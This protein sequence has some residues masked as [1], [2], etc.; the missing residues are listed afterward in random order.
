MTSSADI[1][2]DL[3]GALTPEVRISLLREEL[4]PKLLAHFQDPTAIKLVTPLP[5]KTQDLQIA[6]TSALDTILNE[7]DDYHKVLFLQSALKQEDGVPEFS[8]G[9]IGLLIESELIRI[10]ALG[11][12]RADTRDLVA[13][14]KK[15]L[16]PQEP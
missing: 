5:P 6:I 12:I 14:F 4:E 15:S 8:E 7:L 11:N 1:K 2:V 16:M 9:Q 13:L 10:Q 3:S